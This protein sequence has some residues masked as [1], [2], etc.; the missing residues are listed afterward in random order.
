MKRTIPAVFG[1]RGLKDTEKDKSP[2]VASEES[3]RAA[4]AL[5]ED[6]VGQRFLSGV[7]EQGQRRPK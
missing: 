6:K 1:Q 4:R 7:H 3:K 2:E 5:E